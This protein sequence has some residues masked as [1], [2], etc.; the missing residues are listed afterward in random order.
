MDDLKELFHMRA[1]IVQELD[2]AHY[3]G[4]LVRVIQLRKELELINQRIQDVKKSSCAKITASNRR[5]QDKQ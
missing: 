1:W 3:E 2:I 4:N 5:S